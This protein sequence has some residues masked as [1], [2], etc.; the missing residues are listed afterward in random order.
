MKRFRAEVLWRFRLKKKKVGFTDPQ[1]RSLT[2][3]VASGHS[4]KILLQWLRTSSSVVRTG[5]AAKAFNYAQLLRTV[6][7]PHPPISTQQSEICPPFRQ[8][9]VAVIKPC[10]KVH[11]SSVADP[12][13][14][15]SVCSHATVTNLRVGLPSNL[16]WTYYMVSV[17]NATLLNEGLWIGCSPS[18]KEIGYIEQ[19]FV[20]WIQLHTPWMAK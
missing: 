13:A 5:E 17:T 4:S 14:T 16:F 3:T 9:A 8:Q 18:H 2:M 15:C 11:G 7:R 10:T 12:I 6:D 19:D 20:P 1:A